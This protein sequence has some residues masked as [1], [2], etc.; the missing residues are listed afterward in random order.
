MEDTKVSENA[1]HDVAPNGTDEAELLYDAWVVIANAGEGDW[2]KEHPDWQEA[3][4]RWRDRWHA[5]LETT[6]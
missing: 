1:E 2:T 5:H 4:A 6:I 3:A